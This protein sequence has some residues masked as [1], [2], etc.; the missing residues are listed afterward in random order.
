MPT[1]PRKA[2]DRRA[3]HVERTVEAEAMPA[4]I[5]RTLLRETVESYL[6]PDAL[7]TAR[8]AEQSERAFLQQWANALGRAAP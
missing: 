8:V 4:H 2:G 1:K 3:R 5:L 7:R 6:P